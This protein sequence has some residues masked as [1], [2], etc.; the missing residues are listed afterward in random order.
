MVQEGRSNGHHGSSM[1]TRWTENLP[2]IPSH[3]RVLSLPAGAN[4]GSQCEANLQ[5]CA[6]GPPLPSTGG[7]AEV[8]EAAEARELEKYLRR[9]RATFSEGGLN[10]HQAVK[11]LRADLE[12]YFASRSLPAMHSCSPI[13]ESGSTHLE[14]S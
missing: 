14:V 12:D 4:S 6:G 8:D 10:S 13:K 2:R 11:P 5:P 3:S 7:S 1:T 9:E